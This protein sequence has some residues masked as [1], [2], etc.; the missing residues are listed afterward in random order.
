M[1]LVSMLVETTAV[2]EVCV[3][4]VLLTTVER[5]VEVLGVIE[6]VVDVTD[7]AVLTSVERITEVMNVDSVMTTMLEIVG[8][9]IMLIT[10]PVSSIP[11]SFLFSFSSRS[12][13]TARGMAMARMSTITKSKIP[14]FLRF[15]LVFSCGLWKLKL[16]LSEVIS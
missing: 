12:V 9:S 2:S 14:Q 15:F 3:S 8:A 11:L 5:K 13:L 16:N 1:W 4:V 10:L 6:R 7:V